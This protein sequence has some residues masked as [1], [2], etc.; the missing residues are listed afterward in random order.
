MKRIH[1]DL[2]SN[3]NNNFHRVYIYNVTDDDYATLKR[4]DDDRYEEVWDRLCDRIEQESV[5]GALDPDW[6]IDRIDYK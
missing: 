1:V 4:Y 5:L 6:Y 3:S 2:K